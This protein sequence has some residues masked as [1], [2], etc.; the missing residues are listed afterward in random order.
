M[1]TNKI[2]RLIAAVLTGALMFALGVTLAHSKNPMNHATPKAYIAEFESSDIAVVNTKDNTVIKRIAVPKGVHGVTMMPDGSRVFV[3]SDE[4]NVITVIDAAKDEVTGSILTGK[5]PHGLIARKDG[6]FV[7]AAVFGDDQVLEINTRTLKVERTFDA[8]SPHNLAISP[9]NKTLYVAAQKSGK[10]GI[11]LIDLFSGKLLELHATETVPRSLNVSPDGKVLSVTQFDRSAVQLFTT[12][13]LQL[14]TTIEVG[15]SP[16]HTIFT[17]DGKLLL[18]TSQM[19]N[20]VSLIDTRSWKVESTIPV[21]KKPHWIAPTSDSKYAYVTDEASGQVSFLDLEDKKVD[22]TISVGALPR[23][24]A[25]QPGMV[26]EDDDKAET[27]SPSESK[28][29]ESKGAE[30]KVA[31]VK[32]GG[33]GPRFEPQTLVVEAGTTVEWINAGTRVHTVTDEHAAWDSGSLEPGEKYSKKF[34][35]K[36]TF[37]Y[38]CIP[39][40]EMGMV[41]TVIVK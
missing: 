2:W 6:K 35:T 4:S 8:P 27:G 28:V 26:P 19:D 36:G 38:Y 21:G 11:G 1:K 22:G 13:P 29:A 17:P 31:V 18:V 10:T 34:D 20:H 40:Q 16:H 41:G 39:H 9:D 24:I 32:M 23:K 25:I 37:A 30:S 7:Y 33:S 12:K 3:S 5:A 15:A 14:L